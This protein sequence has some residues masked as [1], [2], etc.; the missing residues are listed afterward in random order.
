MYGSERNWPSPRDYYRN[1]FWPLP[2]TNA[3]GW[4]LVTCPF[5]D[6]HNPSLSINLD[7]GGFNCFA[8]GE[9]G[10]SVSAFN[11]KLYGRKL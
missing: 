8:C 2:E 11:Y 6:D 10:G 7:H 9:S 1:E 5:H 4:A 3:S